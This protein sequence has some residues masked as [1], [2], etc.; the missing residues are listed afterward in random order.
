[1]KSERHVRIRTKFVKLG[2]NETIGH[3]NEAIQYDELERIKVTNTSE[4]NNIQTLIAYD[5]K[6]T[7]NNSST[8][9]NKE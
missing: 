5:I 7:Y 4:D 2:A 6:G 9:E 1:M 8:Y 3:V